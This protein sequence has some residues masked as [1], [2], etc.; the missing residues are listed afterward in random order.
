M[1]RN[2][3]YNLPKALQWLLALL[4]FGLSAVVMGLWFEGTQRN[5][6][7]FFLFPLIMPVFQFAFT[8]LFRLIGMYKY[9]SPMLLVYSPS[10]KK[11]DLHNGTSFDYLF[12]MRK[13]EKGRNFQQLTLWYYLE[14]LLQII[15]ELEAGDIPPEIEI[16]GTSYFFSETTAKRL[17][18]EIVAINSFLKFNL[19]MNFIDLT[20]MYSL[21]K[22]Q[23]TWPDLKGAQSVKTTGAVLLEQKAYLQELH[24]YLQLKTRQLTVGR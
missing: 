18:F 21:A 13:V 17:G 14:G 15:E 1:D 24:A 10:K 3:F 2:P 5:L 11:Y 22:G 8:P 7:Y 9:L 6:L 4:L 20:W 23:F 12:V 19:Y 16:S